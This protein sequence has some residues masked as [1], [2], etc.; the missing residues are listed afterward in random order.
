M[1]KL[2]LIE[3]SKEYQNS[4]EKY[5]IA[6]KTIN[7]E[8]YYEIYKKALVNF[9]E[10]INKLNEFSKG[11]IL[12]LGLVIISTFWLI[13]NDEIVG[14]TRVRHLGVE[15]EG[16]IDYDISPIYRN[17]GYGTEILKLILEKA[18]EIGLKDVILLCTLNNIASKKIIE[19]NNG[20]FLEVTFDAEDNKE[21]YKYRIINNKD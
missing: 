14:V 15:T 6:Y 11:K 7:D 16:N 18:K 2:L 10:Y 20:T 3:P 8:Y 17:K 21:L 5:V 12:P 1:K 9:D 19:K 4:F 13:D